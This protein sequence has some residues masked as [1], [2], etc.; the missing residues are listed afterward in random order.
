MTKTKDLTL[1]PKMSSNIVVSY[2]YCHLNLF[3]YVQYL[4]SHTKEISCILRL[5][6][7]FIF[8]EN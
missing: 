1:M 3:N 7:V 2:F 4:I 8:I 6:K 5:K